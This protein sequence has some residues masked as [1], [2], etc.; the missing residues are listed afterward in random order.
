MLNPAGDLQFEPRA[1]ILILKSF[2]YCS[3]LRASISPQSGS[4][5][6]TVMMVS[7]KATISGFTL[8]STIVIFSFPLMKPHFG[9]E[10]Q[11]EQMKLLFPVPTDITCY[12]SVFTCVA[13][14]M[15]YASSSSSRRLHSCR[16]PSPERD[17]FLQSEKRSAL[18]GVLNQLKM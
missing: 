8:S 11:R 5:S 14:K 12:L 13:T 2:S 3:C 17:I 7:L 9:A 6:L 16:S 4:D 1:L 18:L 10:E 15:P